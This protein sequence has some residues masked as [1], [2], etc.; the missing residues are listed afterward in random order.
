MG[1]KDAKSNMSVL[2]W[3]GVVSTCVVLL[4]TASAAGTWAADTRYVTHKNLIASEIRDLKREIRKIE[5]KRDRG[6]AEDYELD[7]L[8]DLKVEVEELEREYDEK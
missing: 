5:K 1:L 8:K 4:G 3:I 7:Y 2:D 6:Q